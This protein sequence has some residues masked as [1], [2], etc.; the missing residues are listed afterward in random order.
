MIQS[1]DTRNVEN[2]MF[3][4]PNCMLFY[5]RNIFYNVME[6]FFLIRGYKYG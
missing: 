3:R 5:F 2:E 1:M 6:K 4:E